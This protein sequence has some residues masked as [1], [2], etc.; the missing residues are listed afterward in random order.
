MSDL[1]NVAL[2]GL[3]KKEILGKTVL[4]NET[5]R[6]IVHSLSV[7]SYGERLGSNEIAANPGECILYVNQDLSP[8]LQNKNVYVIIAVEESIR[9]WIRIFY[10][11]PY[12]DPSMVRISSGKLV[13]LD[14][15]VP[16]S[17][18]KNYSSYAKKYLWGVLRNKYQGKNKFEVARA[19]MR[20]ANDVEI[21]S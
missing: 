2:N 11:E 10:F 1:F 9:H 3:T 8:N 4:V 12:L 6:R 7:P 19:I 13:V 21:V 17:V 18:L 16:E 5:K 20:I 15:P 14:V